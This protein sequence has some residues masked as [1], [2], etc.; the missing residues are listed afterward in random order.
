MSSS[1]LH[2]KEFAFALVLSAVFTVA[3]FYSTLEAPVL[4]DKVLH[5][6]FPEVFYDV[7][8]T[9]RALSVLRPIGYPALAI[10]IA[11]IL[12]GFAIKKGVLASLGSLVL[13]IPTFGYF[14]YAMF[15]LTGLG[16]LRALWLPL[17]E[18]SPS[19]LKLGCIVYLPFSYVPQAPLVGLVITFI[20]L[21][22]FLLGVTT[23]LYGRFKGYEIVDFWVYRHSRHPQYLGFILW[24]Y[25]LLIFVSNKVYVRGAFTTPPALIWLTSSM[26][27]I[28]IAL[29]EELE[30]RKRYGV[31]YEEYCKKT[32]F[33]VP[34]PGILTRAIKT[35][36]RFAGGY[37]RSMRGIALAIT[38]YT[39]IL[40]AISY[41]L[42]LMSLC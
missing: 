5:Q 24:S 11:L 41:V 17:L 18:L 39:A 8:A 29:F 7:E 37:L 23:W 31:R 1:N 15:F 28:G 6:Y 30:M 40:I 22:V 2:R 21:F 34:L 25:G 20:G 33:M 42:M 35:P 32:P 9:E 10:T 27:V 4:L 38:P 19:T 13:Y 3:L 16:V 12:L 26:L 36:L 14:A